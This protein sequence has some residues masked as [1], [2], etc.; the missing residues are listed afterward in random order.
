MATPYAVIEREEIDS[1]QDE[2]ARRVGQAP[3][4]VVAARQSAGRGRTGRSWQNA[5]R[6]LAGSLAFRPAGWKPAEFPRLSLVA[7]LAACSVLGEE[8][9]CKWPNDLI[10][11]DAKVA[12]LLLETSGETVVAGLGVNLWWPEAPEGYGSVFDRDP[13]P[14]CGL[15]AAR[16][17]AD[18]LLQRVE[19]GPELWGRNEYRARCRTLGQT[20]R[21]Q[22]DGRGVARDIDECGRLVVDTDV[23][24][25]HLGAGEVWEVR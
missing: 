2:A 14:E 23:G 7:A 19:A 21:W 5:P 18:D 17:W 1:T 15:K 10:R 3:I 22:P 13:G 16:H 4:L 6:G 20:V 9:A 11:D 8:V 25:V 12:G 24:V